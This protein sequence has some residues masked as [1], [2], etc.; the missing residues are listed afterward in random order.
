[1]VAGGSA[2][3][4]FRLSLTLRPP[5]TPPTMPRRPTLTPTPPPP[6]TVTTGEDGEPCVH[7]G[8]T[9]YA[10]GGFGP[11]TVVLCACCQ[12]WGGRLGAW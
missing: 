6:P 4:L 10:L 1:M 9:D 7:C 12:V 11:R 8:K 2:P 3:R 5:Q